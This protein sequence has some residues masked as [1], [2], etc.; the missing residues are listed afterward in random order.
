MNK[1]KKLT[2]SYRDF[3][4]VPWRSDA[5][6]GQRVIFC[7][8]DGKDELKLRSRLLNLRL[9]LNRPDMTGQ[10]LTSQI[11]LPSGFQARNTPQAIS[12][13]LPN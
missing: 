10:S 6:P 5:A 9:R 4:S 13:R 12:R 2:D 11:L 3:I 7:V 8:Y 1:I